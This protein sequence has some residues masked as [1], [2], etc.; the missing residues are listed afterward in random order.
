MSRSTLFRMSLAPF[1]HRALAYAK[2]VPI[3]QRQQNF[4]HRH[5]SSLKDNDG[6]IEKLRSS[7]G[8]DNRSSK[9]QEADLYSKQML[10]MSQTPK[11]T[12]HHYLKQINEGVKSQGWKSYIPYLNSVGAAKQV[13]KVK[14]VVEATASL[15][16]EDIG[17]D[18]L[19]KMGQKEK[20]KICIASGADLQDINELIQ[21]F[22]SFE[23]LHRILRY[24]FE[25][26]L[27]LPTSEED[28]K[29]ILQTDAKLVLTA[30]EKR[31]MQQS[32]TISMGR[33]R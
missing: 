14:G 11:L 28:A 20:L 27:P 25:R 12:L 13:Q 22:S 16:G 33:R 2:H 32:R 4:L 30:K 24:R 10:E 17:A 23:L 1:H 31:E 26:N 7:I 18:E 19:K 3:T 9:Q 5:L 21:Q 15:L 8:M 29:A 6:V